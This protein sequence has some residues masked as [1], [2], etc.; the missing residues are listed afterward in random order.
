VFFKSLLISKFMSYD[1]ET[2]EFGTKGLTLIE[3]VNGVGK[4]VPWDAIS[5]CF[6]GLT[7]RG[8]KGDEVVSRV[9]KKDCLVS[10]D[11]DCKGKSL[12]VTRTRKH[13][14]YGNTLWFELDGEKIEESSVADTQAKLAEIVGM[15]FQLFRCTVIF[16]QE[17][18]FNFVD[19]TD[20][21]QKEILS[22]V[23]N[24]DFK[25]KLKA[26]RDAVKETGESID[27]LK[28]KIGVLESHVEENPGDDLK[29][30]MLAWDRDRRGSIAEHKEKIAEYK[31]RLGS[32][33]TTGGDLDELREEID[34]HKEIMNNFLETAKGLEKKV[35]KIQYELT[36]IQ[37]RQKNRSKLGD[38]CPMC[39]QPIDGK[40]VEDNTKLDIDRRGKLI[41]LSKKIEAAR[42]NAYTEHRKAD[43]DKSKAEER[44][45]EAK[46]GA[47]E[48]IRIT[49]WIKDEEESISNLLD[50][51]N[52]FK[53]KIKEA[54]DKQKLIKQ[55]LEDL[56]LQKIKLDE[57]LP[58][59]LFWEKAFSDAGIKSFLFDTMCSSLTNRANEFLNILSDGSTTIS[60]DTQTLLKSGDVRE[61]F[62]CI[63]TTDGEKVPYR[64][65]SGGEKR[66]I[67]LA[68]DMSL[69]ALMSDYYGSKFN[70]VVFD[71]QDFYLDC[72][73][74]DSYHNLLK[75]ISKTKHVFVV[76]HDS[77]LKSRFEDTI[78]VAKVGGLTQLRS[79]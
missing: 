17:D 19:E 55:K 43:K 40:L 28:S 51:E 74:R 58:Y 73:G 16:A 24:I 46:A 1:E 44:L 25:T 23:R 39:E 69:S 5:F 37:T 66:R 30:E 14:E 38:E 64:S 72:D 56:R 20:K 6:F 41:A 78:T 3:G 70:I 4:T 61:K 54:I 48:V 52:P 67:S 76:S 45:T 9:F 79:A 35:T 12:K 53:A 57:D 29:V 13:K 32:I 62:E 36:L 8:L 42:N 34:A 65:Y 15:D 33:E 75:E 22:K 49:G 77:E 18:M 26:F 68:V 47:G 27:G 60:F 10:V 71:E 31:E 59:D 11:C 63:V 21:R 50:K 2:I 7:V